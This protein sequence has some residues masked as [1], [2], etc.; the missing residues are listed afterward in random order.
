MLVPAFA[1]WN[2]LPCGWVWMAWGKGQGFGVEEQE[3]KVLW[4]TRRCRACKSKQVLATWPETLSE[5]QGRSSKCG[6]LSREHEAQLDNVGKPPW[7]PMEAGATKGLHEKQLTWVSVVSW[8]CT[9]GTT[10]R[11]RLV[12]F[13]CVCH[14]QFRAEKTNAYFRN[15]CL[16]CFPGWKWSA[17]LTLQTNNFCLSQI[18]VLLV[19]ENI[20]CQL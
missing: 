2:L 13:A 10:L 9:V 12:R 8:W 5:M 6:V 15:D 14:W 7:P 3:T 20:F 11:A 16:S 4:N 19:S 17:N 18:L 1:F